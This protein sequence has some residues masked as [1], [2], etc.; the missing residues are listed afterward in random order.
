MRYAASAAYLSSII[1]MQGS[2]EPYNYQE[3]IIQSM[4]YFLRKGVFLCVVDGAIIFLDL[5]GDRYISLEAKMT[6]PLL[7]HLSKNTKLSIGHAMTSVKENSDQKGQEIAENNDGFKEC[8]A[9]LSND[10]L[11]T[12]DKAHTAEQPFPVIKIPTLDLSGYDFDH[13]PP[14]TVKHVGTFFWACCRA[15]FKVKFFTTERIARSVR[16]RKRQNSISTDTDKIRDLVEIFKILRPVF[17]T[18]QGHCLF[19]SLALIEFMALYD[20][21]P[22]WVFGVKMGPFQ[23]HCWVQDINFIYNEDI[24]KAHFFTPIMIV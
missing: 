15:F 8:L 19:D 18:A 21:Y 5:C 3:A 22:D 17:F 6:F 11:L 24:D 1:K 10:N 2:Q 14:L 16:N 20:I 23:A 13:K 7:S 9:D 12:M 4:Q